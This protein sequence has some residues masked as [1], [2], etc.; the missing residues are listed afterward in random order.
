M[1]RRK[2]VLPPFHGEHMRAYEE[3]IR[4]SR[5]RLK[6]PRIPS[7]YSSSFGKAVSPGRFITGVKKK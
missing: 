1:R 3:T 4:A 5:N 7:G 6:S 2:L